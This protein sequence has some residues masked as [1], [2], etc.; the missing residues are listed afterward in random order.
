MELETPVAAVAYSILRLIQF[1]PT[2]FCKD[3]ENFGTQLMVRFGKY[4]SI[5]L[6]SVKSQQPIVS[7]SILT[8]LIPSQYR[9]SMQSLVQT[10]KSAIHNFLGFSIPGTNLIPL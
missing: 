9:F 1:D 6:K 5:F 7:S 4:L 8:M 2:I 3:L 10:F